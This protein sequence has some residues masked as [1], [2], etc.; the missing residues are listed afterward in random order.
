MKAVKKLMKRVIPLTLCLTM[1]FSMFSLSTAS[2]AG[3][4]KRIAGSNRYQTAMLVA[5]SLK[6]QLNVN[7]FETII[8]ASGETYADALA[9][10]YLACVKSAPIL[11][12]NEYNESTV[13]NY[14]GKNLKAGGK[15][16]LLGGTGAVSRDF[17]DS[18]KS[19]G[20]VKRL[21][22]ADRF[23]TNMKILNE[24]GTG[25]EELLICS[26][27]DFADS[28]SAS[29]VGKPILLVDISLSGAQQNLIRQAQSDVCYM[30]GGTGAV[31]STVENQLHSLGKDTYR[32]AGNNRFETSAY[33]AE[34][35]F[36]I[37]GDTVML[38]SGDDFPDGLVGGP[39]SA[40][41]GVPLLLVNDRNVYWA[42]A[43][44]N[45]A[46]TEHIIALGG[47]TLI[48]D[49][50]I[51]SLRPISLE[52]LKLVN[53]ERNAA[54][55][56]SLKIDK[57][58]NFVAQLKAADMIYNGYFDHISPTY[59]D[60][61]EMLKSFGIQ[62]MTAGENIAAGQRTPQQV[63]DSWMNSPGHRA[64]ILEPSFTHIG[65]GCISDAWGTP[66]WVQMFIG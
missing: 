55:L 18:A 27:M 16:Y 8:V 65:I 22:G 5:D 9:G 14:I 13:K 7:K 60:P 62:F 26:A 56:D 10:S 41:M 21:G 39:L 61:F 46:V 35:F 23:E 33:V 44:T 19:L 48:S 6:E 32:I 2:A 42:S 11:L 12:V 30:I 25:S 53:K 36:D 52:V 31:S 51:E 24:A 4:D 28:L 20:K 49:S 59:G 3:A 57:D 15:I 50:T 66:Y 64:N 37:Y 43:Y 34:T 45:L 63:M 40:A 58:V 54:G 29:A 1:I 17:E 38:A 47:R